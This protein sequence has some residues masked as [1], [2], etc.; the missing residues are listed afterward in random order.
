[1]RLQIKGVCFFKQLCILKRR[2]GPIKLAELR[3][4]FL[5]KCL[6]QTRKSNGHVYVCKMYRVYLYLFLPLFDWILELFRHREYFYYFFK[7][8]FYEFPSYKL[9]LY[10]YARS[11]AILYPSWLI[12]CSV[13]L[14]TNIAK[15]L[16]TWLRIA[17]KQTMIWKSALITF[18]WNVCIDS[19]Y[20]VHMN[21][22]T[23]NH[24]FIWYPDWLFD[25]HDIIV[26]TRNTDL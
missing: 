22:L 2:V 18:V 3:H 5:L 11:S 14:V 10:P 23:Q 12:V 25:I 15:I 20:K 19:I 4:F 26:T 21:V 1:M 7:D 17:I 16:L 8:Y 9:N 6:Y 13:F 24:F